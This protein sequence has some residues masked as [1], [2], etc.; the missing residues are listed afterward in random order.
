MKYCLHIAH[1]PQ[2]ELGGENAGVLRLVFLQNVG[3]HGAAHLRERVGFDFFIDVARQDLS[4]VTPSSISP[5]PSL[6][7]GSSPW[8]SVGARSLSP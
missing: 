6:P 3:L 2:R 8:Y 7:S 1:Q 4:P 5:R